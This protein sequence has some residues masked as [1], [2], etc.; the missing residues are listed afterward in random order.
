MCTWAIPSHETDRCVLVFWNW[1]EVGE[2][3]LDWPE[4]SDGGA[5]P[6]RYIDR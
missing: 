2:T 1:R 5:N 3:V 4:F 6:V